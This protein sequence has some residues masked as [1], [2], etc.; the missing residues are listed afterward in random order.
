MNKPIRFVFQLSLLLQVAWPDYLTS[1]G[2][3]AQRPQT[4]ENSSNNSVY[5]S[6]GSSDRA[7]YGSRTSQYQK[8]IDE[9]N[10]ELNTTIRV[11]SINGGERLDREISEK[12]Q[13]INETQFKLNRVVRSTDTNGGLLSTEVMEEDHQLKNSTEEVQRTFYRPDMNGKLVAQTVEKETIATPS[14]KETLNTRAIYRPDAEGRFAL[15]DLEE[16]SEKKISDTTS[17]RDTARKARDPNGRLALVGSTKETTTKLSDKSFKKESSVHRSDE[18]GR[19]VLTDKVVETQAEKPDGTKL[20]QKLRES[21][22]AHP[23]IRNVDDT[24]LIL[25]QRITGEERKLPD[26]TIENTMKVETL[27]R[28]APSNGLR[29]SEIITETSKSAGNGKVAIERVVKT[30][31]VNG[32]YVVVQKVSQVLEQ[33]K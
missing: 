17:I 22:N 6:L 18:N 33:K 8:L 7:E 15:T 21:R 10:Y 2:S 28:L 24:G 12:S 14:K 29:L 1:Q 3:S 5:S 20:Y 11:P 13:K 25:S 9:K 4:T 19:M 26:G 31:D 30:R 23:Q 32:N 16:S 27:D